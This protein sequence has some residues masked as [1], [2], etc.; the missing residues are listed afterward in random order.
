MTTYRRGQDVIV[1]LDGIDC[2]GVVIQQSSG[3][4]MAR[5]IVA[6]PEAD[7]G[8]GTSLLAPVQ[9]VCVRECN[10]RPCVI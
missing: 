4:V 9:T 1:T 10:V 8:P 2:P 5:I 3:Y 7:Y 6:D